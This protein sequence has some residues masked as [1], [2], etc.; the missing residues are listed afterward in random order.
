MPSVPPRPADPREGG[1]A[2]RAGDG[3]SGRAGDR[4]G[5]G[6]A[7][8]VSGRRAAGGRVAEAEAGMHGTL[9]VVERPPRL[10][11]GGGSDDR[12][13]FTA[14]RIVRFVLGTASLAAGAYLLW[15]FAALVVYLV[16]GAIFA[17]L[18]AP[19]VDRLQ[20][21]G[22]GRSGAI[23][24][25]FVVVIGVIS[26]GVTSVVPF[27]AEQVRELTQLVS[28]DAAVDAA[29]RVEERLRAVVPF[30]KGLLVDG[31]REVAR[32]LVTGELTGGEYFAET[33]SSV[34]AV[35][36]NLLYAVIIIP[37][38]TFFLLKDGL[39]IRRSLLQVVP[40]RYFEV[41]LA[42]VEKVETSVGRYFRA[43]LMQCVS[44]AVIASTLLT[45][46]GLDNAVAIGIFTGLANTIPYFGPFIGF[47]TGA[48][49]GI[50][51]TGDFSLVFGVA[52]AMALTQLADNVLLQPLIFSRAANA[53]PL[54]ILF[55]VLIGAQLAGIV[56][57]LVAIPLA[58]M[59][60][61]VVEQVLWSVRNY[62]ILRA[63]S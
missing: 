56:G 18:L 30:E 25:A 2:T 62:R 52:V 9:P 47:V 5:D 10:A 58:T 60:R 48:L 41:T 34:W 31:V 12:R 23:L 38:V 50:A 16:V 37:F 57:M 59:V 53:H 35:L 1:E 3:R 28:V 24:V 32:S 42:I 45:F 19:M 8:P 40:N 55:V 54:V 7:R 15:Y 27:M 51:Q 36:T 6:E 22:L 44:V 20:G 43:L 4:S 17:Y 11:S 29:H 63:G 14:D 13:T 26:V 46:T 49:V 21:F 39:Q 33:M 61:V